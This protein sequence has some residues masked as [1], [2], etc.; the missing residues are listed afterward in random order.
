LAAWYLGLPE[1]KAK[2]GYSRDRLSINRLIPF[3]GDRLLK[4]ITPDLVEAYRQKR[5]AEPSG[6]TPTTLT[7][8]ATVN[9]EIAC[10][11]TIFNKALKNGKVECNPAQGVKM[12]KEN[13]EG[14]RV[15]SPE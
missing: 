2:R 8:P 7:A 13:N 3:F 4:D 11:K 12:L 6:R 1:V 10:F 9:R 14:D 15:L 5:L